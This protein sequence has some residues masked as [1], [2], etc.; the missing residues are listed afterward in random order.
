M[1]ILEDLWLGKIAP[2]QRPLQTNSPYHQLLHTSVQLE[3]QLRSSMDMRQKEWLDAYSDSEIQMLNIAETEAFSLGFQM[4][5]QLL[6]AALDK[7]Q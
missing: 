1:D 4:G 3:T 6:L 7:C 5:I 2:A